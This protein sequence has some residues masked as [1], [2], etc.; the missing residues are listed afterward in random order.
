[1]P[2]N[3]EKVSRRNLAV[4]AFLI[5]LPPIFQ[6]APGFLMGAAGKAAWLSGLLTF[7]PLLLYFLFLRLFLK[8]RAEGEGLSELFLRALGPLA[9]RAAL[10][11]NALWFLFYAG[12]ALRAA[13]ARLAD[14]IY[15]AAAYQFFT[16]ATLLIAAVAAFGRTG[17]LI[18]TGAHLAPFVFVVIGLIFLL[19]LPKLD[20]KSLLPL[21][22]GDTVPVLSGAAMG[23][24]LAS[25]AAYVAFFTRDLPTGERKKGPLLWLAFFVALTLAL[26]CAV[27]QSAFG[28]ALTQKLNYPFFSMIRDI[29]LFKVLTRYEAMIVT[30]WTLGDYFLSALLLLAGAGQLQ[31]VFH[32]AV[33]EDPGKRLP[34]FREGRWTIWLSVA[35]ALALS[36]TLA[37]RQ[38]ELKAL[39]ETVIP[40]VKWAVALGLYPLVFV[41]G[42]IRKTI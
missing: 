18:R 21:R 29:T 4:L 39:A 15:P 37:P 14:T 2:Q 6:R 34:L 33:P 40:A 27:C 5:L 41:I 3:R 35:A 38:S 1:M 19:A 7:V 25:T 13:G 22:A 8:N 28:P 17:A 30:I 42:K 11:L 31:L 23:F 10:L 16:V 26:L 20:I 9:G 36:L 24:N 12:F 32:A